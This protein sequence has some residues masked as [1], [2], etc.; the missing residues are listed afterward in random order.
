MEIHSIFYKSSHCL[1]R[2]SEAVN[3]DIDVDVANHPQEK[4]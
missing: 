2:C 3:V 4:M 1:V